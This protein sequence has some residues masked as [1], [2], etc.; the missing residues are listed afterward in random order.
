MG[1]GDHLVT[2]Q[3]PWHPW[4][5]TWWPLGPCSAGYGGPETPADP[6]TLRTPKNSSE[7]QLAV[8]LQGALSKIFYIFRL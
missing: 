1:L 5:P 4:G 2:I 6:P 7:Q 8:S 3:V